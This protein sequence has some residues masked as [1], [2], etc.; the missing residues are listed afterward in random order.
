MT[1]RDAGRHGQIV[2]TGGSGFI[3]RAVVQALQDR[4]KTVLVVDRMP[5]PETS[6]VHSVTGDLANSDVLDAAVTDD[7][8][9]IIHLAARTSVLKSVHA[10]MDTYTA[11]V[12]VTARLLDRARQHR[13]PRFVF[14]STNAVV[15]DVGHHTITPD[16]PLRPLT[17]YGATKAAGEMLLSGYAGAYQMR[18]CALRFTNVYGP[19]MSGKDSFVP[20]IMRAAR[21]GGTITVFGDGHQRRDL[22]HV[23]DVVTGILA[24]LDSSFVGTAILGS[25]ASVSVLDLLDVAREVTGTPLPAEHVPAKPGEMP[26]VICDISGS[27]RDLGFRP[28]VDLSSGLADTWDYFRNGQGPREHP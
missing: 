11:N 4:N 15:G 2:V 5:F 26:A 22:I 6:G 21:D 10:P 9:A 18:T 12:D 25:G 20:R 1:Q 17:P 28:T 23:D 3:G 19:G 13:V 24:A 16:L 14:A 27:E 8:D 7:T